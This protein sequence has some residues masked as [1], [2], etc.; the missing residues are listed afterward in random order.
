LLLDEPFG[1]LDAQVRVEL[2]RWLRRLHE[3]I[4]VTSVFVTHD[5]E[6]ALEVADVVVVMSHGKIEQVGTPE[7]VFHRPETEFVM[8]FIGQVNQF[9]GR[10]T[11][12]KGVF[13][14]L[15]IDDDRISNTD[16]ANAKLFVR[17]HDIRVSSV[18]SGQSEVSVTVM[19]VHQA[20][21]RVRMDLRDS[22]NRMVHVDMS[23]DDYLK[24]LLKKDDKAFVS[25]H[26]SR[27][28]INKPHA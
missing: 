22:E 25:L 26:N 1:A 15:V 12:G 18:P 5:Q 19:H 17:P 16:D 10:V 2:R 27:I 7:D 11:E 3:E 14:E 13:G 9:H 6:E 24:T 21:P 4:H 20:G 8:K 28:F 23:H